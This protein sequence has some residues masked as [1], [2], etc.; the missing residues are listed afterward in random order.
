[1]TQRER[2][3]GNLD[4]AA[5]KALHGAPNAD[6][7]MHHFESMARDDQATAIRSMAASGMSEL[8]LS[9]ATRLSV[10]QIRR[11]LGEPIQ[12]TAGEAP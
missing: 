7:R 12:P 4:V 6:P 5:M 9:A 11:V 1:M 10:E 3:G 2:I 8:A